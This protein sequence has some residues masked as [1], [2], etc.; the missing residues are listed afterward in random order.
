MNTELLNV[1]K[2]NTRFKKLQINEILDFVL[3]NGLLTN[4]IIY[5][6]FKC[7]YGK[8]LI[9]FKH[10]YRGVELFIVN[11]FFNNA[12]LTRIYLSLKS[13]SLIT[14][15]D[16]IENDLSILFDKWFNTLTKVTIDYNSKNW[17]NNLK[18]LV[19]KDANIIFTTYK[20]FNNTDKIYDDLRT[21]HAGFS[22]VFAVTDGDDVHIID[23]RDK[24][25]IVTSILDSEFQHYITFNYLN[26]HIT[27]N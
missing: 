2:L 23:T 4:D 13:E 8:S 3:T 10:D 22:K 16:I 7:R 24:R 18:D 1:L 19:Y 11:S 17:E 26:K 9:K 14:F 15:N 12:N 21:T 27:L 6:F 5:E 20:S 25:L